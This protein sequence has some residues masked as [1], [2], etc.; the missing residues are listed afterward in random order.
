[1]KGGFFHLHHL[2]PLSDIGSDT[3]DCVL[4]EICRSLGIKFTRNTQY[5]TELFEKKRIT[6]SSGLSK[7]TLRE[8]AR[9]LNSKTNWTA[10]GLLKALKFYTE[11]K[12]LDLDPLLDL[13][14]GEQTASLPKSLNCRMLYFLC[15]KYG[16]EASPLSDAQSLYERLKL[17]HSFQSPNLLQFAK[18]RVVQGLKYELEEKDLVNILTL[19]KD[20]TF[21]SSSAAQ[22]NKEENIREKEKEKVEN[23]WSFNPEE[24]DRCSRGID[25]D[26]IPETEHQAIALA[27]LNFNLDITRVKDPIREYLLMKEETYFPFDREFKGALQQSKYFPDSLTNPDITVNFSPVL[28]PT[29]YTLEVLEKLAREEGIE[30]AEIEEIDVGNDDYKKE[31]YYSSLVSAC[32]TPTFFPRLQTSPKN[33][34]T[35]FLEPVE[36]LDPHEAISF[37]KKDTKEKG[38]VF[39]YSELKETF[40]KTNNFHNPQS[41]EIFTDTN[42]NKLYNLCKKEKG[43]GE[44]QWV[45]RDRENLAEEIERVKLLLEN[46]NSY[47]KKFAGIYEGGGAETR[48]KILSFLKLLLESGMYMRGWKG[49]G[50]YP[51]KS[52]STVFDISTEQANVDKRVMESL[53]SLEDHVSSCKD[54]SFLLKGLPLMRWIKES[55]K[56]I[57]CDDPKEGL[58][59]WDRVQIIKKGTD[60]NS[61]IRLSSNRLCATA[62]YYSFLLKHRLRFSMEDLDNIG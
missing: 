17:F 2:E 19:L 6:I 7:E 13:P 24:L 3:P 18:A 9:F 38:L 53:F 60:P 31:I 44:P 54:V 52:S 27:A 51:L 25:R 55:K 50:D 23:K 28:P 20:K 33:R 12:A 47:I 15:K 48:D 22:E 35:T 62:Y 30:I 43:V 29:L 37:F 59:I 34:E 36:S 40:S 49:K 41:G 5:I 32:S 16:L 46:K 10:D 21:L 58:T 1:M 4:E 42:I 26:R 61:C 45:Y 8:L 39:T 57:P 14:V 56:F 11:F